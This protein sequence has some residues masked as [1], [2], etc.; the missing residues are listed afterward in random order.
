MKPIKSPFRIILSGSAAFAALFVGWHYLGE[1]SEQGAGNLPVEGSVT[2]EGS[3]PNKSETNL[4]EAAPE[5]GEPGNPMV[6]VIPAEQKR[7]YLEESPVEKEYQSAGRSPAVV[8][9]GSGPEAPAGAFEPAGGEKP[10]GSR[11]SPFGSGHG[12]GGFGAGG[13]G[14]FRGGSAGGGG[15]ASSGS[16]GSTASNG[17]SDGIT[18]VTETDGTNLQLFD[19]APSPT[20]LGTDSDL[21]IPGTNNNPFVGNVPSGPTGDLAG[22]GN[23]GDGIGSPTGNPDKNGPNNFSDQITEQVIAAITT[24]GTGGHTDQVPEDLT[25]LQPRDPPMVPDTASALGLTVFSLLLLI[26]WRRRN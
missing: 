26:G 17:P 21:G 10:A 18:L 20:Q 15:G 1:P 4:K 13:G 3:V 7:S 24:P 5:R 9:E 14:G 6:G 11:F 25:N 12:G 8:A 2:G 16:G 22:T 19:P 23:A